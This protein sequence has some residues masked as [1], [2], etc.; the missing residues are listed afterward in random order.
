MNAVSCWGEDKNGRKNDII[1]RKMLTFIKC[2]LYQNVMHFQEL[3]SWEFTTNRDIPR[4][5]LPAADV[6]VLG[7]REQWKLRREKGG[8][9]GSIKEKKKN[10]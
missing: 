1:L 4:Q 9:V 8:K 2:K 5:D 3:F 10:S 7:K 6:F